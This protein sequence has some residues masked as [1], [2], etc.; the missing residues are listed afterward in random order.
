[1]CLVQNDDAVPVEIPFVQRLSQKYAVSHIWWELVESNGEKGGISTFDLSFGGGTVFKPNSITNNSPQF[2]L[3]DICK[4][5]DDD[6]ER[7]YLHFFTHA[8]GD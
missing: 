7:A 1:M 2:T 3:Q 5:T 6:K 8:L 4:R